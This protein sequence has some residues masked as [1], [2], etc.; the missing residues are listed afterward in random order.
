MI[1]QYIQPTIS[2]TI[3]PS[4]DP[5]LNPTPKPSTDPTKAPTNEP[6]ISPTASPTISPTAHSETGRN[7][8]RYLTKIFFDHNKKGKIADIEEVGG[9]YEENEYEEEQEY[10]EDASRETDSIHG[11]SSDDNL[12]ADIIDITNIS[13]SKPSMNAPKPMITDNVESDH[14][15]TDSSGDIGHCLIADVDDVGIAADIEDAEDASGDGSGDGSGAGSGAGSSQSTHLKINSSSGII[16]LIDIRTCNT[17]KTFKCNTNTRDTKLFWATNDGQNKAKYFNQLICLG[18]GKGSVVGTYY[19]NNCNID[20]NESKEEDNNND[21]DNDDN[22]QNIDDEKKADAAADDDDND[23]DIEELE[24]IATQSF[25]VSNAIPIG[26]Y[27]SNDNLF[28]VSSIG[29]RKIRVYEFNKN[30][31]K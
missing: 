10:K 4:T 6:T 26:Y 1:Q 14:Q 27:D 24:C 15:D 2:P 20:I 21:D 17:L 8:Y 5:T 31:I 12:A 25:G 7:S 22:E 18:F 13:P 28:Y 30:G 16:K 9:C 3:S 11:D 19:N 29:D 23:D